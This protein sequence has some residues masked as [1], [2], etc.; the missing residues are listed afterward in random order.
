MDPGGSLEG[1]VEAVALKSPS[2]DI[3][4]LYVVLLL[5]VPLFIVLESLHRGTGLAMSIALWV[6]SEI[7]GAEL[8]KLPV[9]VRLVL[10]SVCLAGPFLYSA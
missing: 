8:P 4:P 3:L 10:R 6:T 5:S 9:S 1:C 7:T 2:T